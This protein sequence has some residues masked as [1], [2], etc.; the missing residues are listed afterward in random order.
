MMNALQSSL[1]SPPFHRNIELEYCASIEHRSSMYNLVFLHTG[2][3][4]SK[5]MASSA[6]ALIIGNSA[7]VEFAEA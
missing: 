4:P 6:M 1:L 7:N 2:V 3:R 5:Q